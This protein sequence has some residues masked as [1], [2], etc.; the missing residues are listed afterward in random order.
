MLTTGSAKT[1]SS[2]Q[3]KTIISDESLIET[4]H[5]FMASLLFPLLIYCTILGRIMVAIEIERMLSEKAGFNVEITTAQ[6]GEQKKAEQTI[7]EFVV[8]QGIST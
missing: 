8:Q 7:E 3:A 2:I 6:K 4:P 5:I 1:T